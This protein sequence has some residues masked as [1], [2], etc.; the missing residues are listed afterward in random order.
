MPSR[1]F[2]G[3]LPH[4]AIPSKSV[5][6]IGVFDGVH[7]AHRQLIRAAARLASKKSSATG[8]ITFDP[9]PQHVLAPGRTQAL[10]P[11][12]ERLALLRNQGADWIWVIPFSRKVAATRAED[13]VKKILYE[14]LRVSAVIVGGGFLFGKDR[15]GTLKTL[16]RWVKAVAIKPVLSRGKAISASRIRQF[17]AQGALS[18]ARLL[19]GRPPALYGRVVTGSGRGRRLGFP[20]A[21]IRLMNQALPPLGVYAVRIRFQ[22]NRRTFNG[23]MN[24][25]IRPTF[26]ENKAVCEAHLFRFKGS[27]VGL[28]AKVEL[29]RRLRSERCF[30]SLQALKSQVQRDIFRARRILSSK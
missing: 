28:M 19:L 8:I 13:F 17:I 21:N 12:H 23:V 26:R 6:T 3:L 29:I 15:E 20:T 11:A 4:K 14:K 30:S 25:G 9:D 2:K 1:L 7:K 16:R 5:V 22:G 24:Y 27:L 10:M 18:Q